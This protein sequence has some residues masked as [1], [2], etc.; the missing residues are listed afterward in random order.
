MEEL[1]VVA[2]TKVPVPVASLN[3]QED[4]CMPLRAI[5]QQRDRPGV[6]RSAA[7]TSARGQ[8]SADE[9]GGIYSRN[10]VMKP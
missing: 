10:P 1:E 8:S 7:G 3:V 5:E 4:Q 9:H 2:M 6:P